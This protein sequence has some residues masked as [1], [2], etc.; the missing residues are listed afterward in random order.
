M[1]LMLALVTLAFAYWCWDRR[2][3][4]MKACPRCRR[5]PGRK[6]SSWNGQAYGTCRRCDGRGEV[7]RAGLR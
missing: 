3:H 7:R 5:S 2:R 6:V 4:P 1:E